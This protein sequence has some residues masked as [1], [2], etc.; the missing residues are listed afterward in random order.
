MPPE[1]DRPDDSEPPPEIDKGL[2]RAFGG[3]KSA[4]RNPSPAPSILQ[5][6]GE[7]TGMKPSI[8]LREIDPAG[9]TPM[10]KPLVAGDEVARETGKY[11]VQGMLGQ[12]GVGTVHKGHDTDLGR[13]VAIKFLHERYAKDPGILHRFVEEAQIGGQLQHPGIVPVYELGMVDGRPFFTM[14]MVKGETLAKKLA[15]RPSPANDRRAFLVI[16]EDI[17]Q[18]MAYAHARGVVHRD[19]KPANIMIGAFGEVQV[20]DWGMGKVLQSGGVAD[21]KLAADRQSQLSV[22]E[23]LR[24]SGHGTQSILGSVMGTPAYMPPEQARGDVDAMDERSDVFSLGAILCEILTGMPPYIGQPNKLISMAAMG[25]LDDAHAR[26]AACGAEADLVEIATM[27]LMPAPAARPQSAGA[28]AAAIH[29]HLASAEARAHDA[30][31]RTLAMKRTQK[32]GI[33]LTIVIAMG[34]AASLWFWRDA[35]AQRGLAEN[36]AT[37]EKQA[38]QLADTRAEEARASLA[39]FNR[40]SH[41]VRLEAA[42]TRED[43]LYPAWPDKS[44]S[45]QSWL[46]DEAKD[47][48]DSLPELRSTLADLERKALPQTKQERVAAR[49]T[50]PRGGELQALKNKLTALRFANEV[51]SGS[52][53]P[54]PFSLDEAN[55]PTVHGELNNL[56][57][58]LVDPE[59][60]EFGRESE[61]LA[62]ARKAVSAAPA[63]GDDRA[64]VTDTLAW[65]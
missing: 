54:E 57:W 16:F 63:T 24:S 9:Q 34:L 27:C 12:G 6:I 62:L 58:A 50:H 25:K 35:D 45:M 30:T 42:K 48:I 1:N 60:K 64:M 51:R 4:S 26:L 3:E 49:S 32:L 7:V 53:K 39:N 59:R 31:V 17:C 61:G 23:T 19:L 11:M 28:V 36:A 13:D 15:E 40:L 43:G 29:S 21:E 65:A 10:L 5:R 46:D 18:T 8:S 38:R 14:K 41:V 37:S 52:R 47:L 2:A 44:D 20:V 55:L 56:A 33:A 22:I